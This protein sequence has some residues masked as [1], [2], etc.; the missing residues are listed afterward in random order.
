MAN[1]SKGKDAKLKGLTLVKVG[2]QLPNLR[3][4]FSTQKPALFLLKGAKRNY[5][6]YNLRFN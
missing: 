3:S 2:S 1:L 6:G 4:F 5:E